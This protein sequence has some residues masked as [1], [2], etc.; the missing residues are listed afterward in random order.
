[1]IRFKK[2]L[3]APVAL[4]VALSS[5]ATAADAITVWP[6]DPHAKIFRDTKPAEG[7]AAVTLRAARNEY[8]PGQIAFR[9]AQTL[10]G[11]RVEFSS[12]KQRDGQATIGGE[13]LVWNFEGFIPIKKNT[14]MLEPIQVRK[15]PCEIP[16]PLLDARTINLPADTT[17]PVWLTVFVPKNTPPGVYQGEVAVV[18][19]NARAAVPVE[20]TVDPFV[21][22][23]ERHVWVTNWFTVN[24]IAKAHKMELWSE[25]FWAMLDRYARN[26]AAHRQNVVL[27][28]WNLIEVA[29][30]ED[31]KLS[32][33]YQRFDRYVQLFERAGVAGQLEISHVG[34]G[35]GGWGQEFELAGVSANDRKTSKPVSLSPQEGLAPL[36]TDLERHL[37]ERGWLAK[38]M[39]HVAD[40]PILSNLDSWRK[41]SAFVRQAA[42]RLRRVE[43]IETIDCNGGLEVWVPQLCHFDRWREAFESRRG[44]GEFWYYIC[45]NPF[46]SLY[47]NRFLD[48]PLSRVRVLHWVNYS[49]RLAGYLHWGLNYWGDDPF[50]TP[51]DRLPPGDTHVL[52]PGTEGPLNSV[53]WEIQRESLEDFEYLHLLAARTGEFKKQHPAAVW[54]DPGR[55]AMELAR[56]V[57]PRITDTELDPAKIMAVRRE[58][59]DEIMALDKAPQLLVQTEPS[60]GSTL[61]QGPIAVELHGITEPGATVKVNG[62]PAEVRADGTFIA[63]VGSAEVRVEA[64]HGENKRVAVRKFVMRP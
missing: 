14:R 61:A 1:M 59:A 60:E 5:I 33:D 19:G 57:V 22:P 18:A 39:I 44:E 28:P 27:V 10:D 37:A 53:R 54:L 21:L 64:V 31:G 4:L 25:P 16:D 46:G 23:D 32:F 40:E 52:Y 35:K 20:L 6:V 24:N 11:V 49:E 42:P 47:P 63:R 56:R 12:L 36:L 41:L 55:R 29:R 9:S 13:N 38:S 3:L 51:G 7:P 30:A 43:A 17:Q 58:L 48:D 34:H 26:M 15:A 8:E 62:Q 45:C 2:A 50:G